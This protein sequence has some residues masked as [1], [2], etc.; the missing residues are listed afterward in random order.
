MSRVLR[1]RAGLLCWV[2]LALL[3]V[4]AFAQINYPNFS[5]SAG[6]NL[7]GNA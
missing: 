3:A 7:V 1:S 5:A 2:F 6:L 4:P